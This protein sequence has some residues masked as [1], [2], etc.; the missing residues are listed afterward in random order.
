MHRE[1]PPNISGL[2]DYV[3]DCGMEAYVEACI[4]V[5][6]LEKKHGPAV[7]VASTGEGWNYNNLKGSLLAFMEN[8]CPDSA[9][10]V[11]SDGFNQFIRMEMYH[12]HM[13]SF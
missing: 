3:C 1:L 5:K 7:A 9:E 11:K 4:R 13:R 2:E 10:Y 12:R 6:K 8:H